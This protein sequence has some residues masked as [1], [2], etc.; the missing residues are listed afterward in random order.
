MIEGVIAVEVDI[1]PRSC[2]N[3]FNTK[4]NGVLPVAILGTADFNV[5][6]VDPS[7]VR[8]EGVA[9]LR[10][11]YED[12]SRPVNPRNQVCD[13][14]TEGPDG[15]GDLNLK[16]DHQAIVSALLPVY[17]G[18]ERVLTLSGSTYRGIPIEGHDCVRIIHKRS[19]KSSEEM[20][21]RFSLGDNYPN[22]FNPRTEFDFTLPVDCRVQIE[23]YNVAGQLVKAYEGDY[24][25]GVHTISWDGTNMNG[26][27]VGSGIYFYRMEAGDFVQ[28][29]KMVLMR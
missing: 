21:A 20:V 25:A 27:D 7:T 9:P 22:P 19:P 29:K 1:K 12:V 18:E 8:L 13:C 23:I 4:S 5:R 2:P 17:D 14:T 6:T 11:S 3:P 28:H 24:P 26:E 15:F 16:F 10:W